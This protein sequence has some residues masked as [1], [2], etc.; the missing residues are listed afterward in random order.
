MAVGASAAVTI[1]P[2]S[3]FKFPQGR[4][5]LVSGSLDAQG[6][7]DAPIIF[8]S[9]NDDSAG[10]DSDGDGTATLPQAG[11]WQGF[12]IDSSTTTL[13]HVHIR[14]AG[15]DNNPGNTFGPYR[16]AAFNIRNGSQPQIHN[17]RVSYAENIG[18]SVQGGSKPLLD[19]LTIEYSGHFNGSGREAIEQDLASDPTYQEVHLVENYAN[20]VTLGAERSLERELLTSTISPSTSTAIYSLLPTRTLPSCL[21]RFSSFGKVTICGVVVF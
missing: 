1:V 12:Y 3:I 20:R 5:F 13:D 6:T 11:Q 16:V 4:Y 17:T 15:N 2:G 10:G 14:Y 8:T 18:L 21:E 19:N 7:A 9:I